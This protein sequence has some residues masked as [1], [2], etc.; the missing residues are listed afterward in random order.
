M[1]MLLTDRMIKKII[2][3]ATL[4]EVHSFAMQYTVTIHCSYYF[5]EIFTHPTLTC[6]T[7][8]LDLKLECKL[9]IIKVEKK[10]K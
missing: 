4:K 7:L 6:F 1:R 9:H 2:Y 5:L 10:T 8:C 3:N